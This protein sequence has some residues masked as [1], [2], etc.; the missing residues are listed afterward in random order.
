MFNDRSAVSIGD[1]PCHSRSHI[2]FHSFST[3]IKFP[4]ALNHSLMLKEPTD[5]RSSLQSLISLHK[6]TLCLGIDAVATLNSRPTL[7][8]ECFRIQESAMIR[9]R[10]PV[11][12]LPG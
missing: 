1:Q 3:N 8:G 11:F 5:N 6:S 7:R 4:V 10:L 12:N 9:K 2:T